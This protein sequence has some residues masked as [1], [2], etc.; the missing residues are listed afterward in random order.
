MTTIN[1][2]LGYTDADRLSLPVNG[3]G[4]YQRLL[5]EVKRVQFG[6]TV[7]LTPEL[8]A[9]ILKAVPTKAKN[10]GGY[11][12]RLRPVADAVRTFSKVFRTR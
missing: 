11:Q 3:K 5:N 4:G 12:Y 2:T 1:I 8:A 9:R 10:L 6:D 7:E